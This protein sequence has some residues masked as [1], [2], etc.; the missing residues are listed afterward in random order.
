MRTATLRFPAFRVV[1]KGAAARRRRHRRRSPLLEPL[2]ARTVLSTIT[3]TSAA[4]SGSGTLRAAIASAQ[5]GDTIKFS[6]TLD[7]HTIN[8]TSG[9]LAIGESLTIE[10]PGLGLINVD[11]GGRSE[12]FDITS[13]A[14]NVTISGLTISGGRAEDGGGILDQGGTLTLSSDTLQ[15]D[16]AVGVNPGD[17]AEGGGVDVTDSGSLVV[18]SC[19]FLNDLAQGAAGAN[20]GT[21]SVNGT[22]GDGDGGAIYADAN[23]NLTVLTSTFVSNQAIGGAGGSGGSGY[24]NGW[25]GNSNGSAIDT[26]GNTLSVT[27]SVFTGDLSEGGN[28]S[29]GLDTQPYAANGYAG[30]GTGSI[31]IESF[32]AS[33]VTFTSDVFYAEKAIGGAGANNTATNEAEYGGGGGSAGGIINNFYGVSNTVIS[34]CGFTL[35][36][37]VGGAGGQGGTG[38]G[39]GYGGDA[40]DSTVFTGGYLTVTNSLFTL[41]Q[42]ISG[43]GGAGGSGGTGGAGGL[44]GGVVGAFASMTL[45]D[46]TFT[47]NVAI[48]G[49]GGP[50]VPALTAAPEEP[51]PAALSL[52]P[53]SWW[54]P[55]V[56]SSPIRQ[57]AEQE[58][59]A[60]Q[61]EREVPAV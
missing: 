29:P 39:G 26:I 53:A 61:Q 40:A 33:T 18:R 44:S 3:V 30:Y 43:P 22:G 5:S 59:P 60:V 21:A 15:N 9:V 1:A 49:K 2:E 17:T 8:L 14:A 37:A 50:G 4:D 35:N 34:N 19:T 6:A 11:A 58:E 23:T 57:S 55:T 45:S 24:E 51:P 46:S 25:G 7:G 12:V 16:Q 42:A 47:G 38:Y 36:V 10:G 13:S 27:G 31:N 56:P 52:W 28:G 32:S 48:G 20:G 41:N 54:R